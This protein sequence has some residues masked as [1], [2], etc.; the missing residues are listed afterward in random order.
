VL[1]EHLPPLGFGLAAGAAASALA[2]YPAACLRGSGLPFAYLLLLAGSIA[3]SALT[4]TV[5]AAGLALRADLLPA[6]RNE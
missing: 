4:F 2:V 3:A 5:I 1:A 6:L